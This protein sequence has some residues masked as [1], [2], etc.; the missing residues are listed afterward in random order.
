MKYSLIVFIVASLV[1]ATAVIITKSGLP[2]FTYLIFV[3]FI[4]KF[5]SGL[6]TEEADEE[7]EEDEK[8]N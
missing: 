5:M 4:Q 8:A 7:I 6:L 3:A 1:I 2:L